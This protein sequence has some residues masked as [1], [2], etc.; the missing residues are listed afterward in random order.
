MDRGRLQAAQPPCPSPPEQVRRGPSPR[1]GASPLA[2]S[3]LHPP[4]SG[5][6]FRVEVLAR[7]GRSRSRERDPVSAEEPVHRDR[8]Q[9]G[10]GGGVADAAAALVEEIG[11]VAFLEGG[12]PALAELVEAVARLGRRC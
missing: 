12:Q 8:A 7:G 1:E 5:T 10:A 3:A 9:A 4:D 6:T 11:E 2:P